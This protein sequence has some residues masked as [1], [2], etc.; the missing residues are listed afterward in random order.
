[1]KIGAWY[2]VTK[3]SDDGTF[4]V[5]DHVSP[6][7]DG[8]IAC[9]EGQGWIEAHEAD[10]A[11]GG[12]EVKVDTAAELFAAIRE[13][14]TIAEIAYSKGD[15]RKLRQALEEAQATLEEALS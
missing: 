5:G 6:L 13:Q 7:A 2:V 4:E 3:G 12:V 9:K 11:M 10:E 15:L 1:M 8:G 14:M